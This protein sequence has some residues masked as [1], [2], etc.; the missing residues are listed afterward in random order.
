MQ[1]EVICYGKNIGMMSEKVAIEKVAAV[2]D[3]WCW[4]RFPGES[5]WTDCYGTK[6]TKE[7]VTQAIDGS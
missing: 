6:Y 7:E 5:V 2:N 4:W 1:V 3:Q